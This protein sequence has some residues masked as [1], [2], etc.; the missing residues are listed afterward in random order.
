MNFGS[1]STVKYLELFVDIDLEDAIA[2]SR[3]NQ[4]LSILILVL[5]CLLVCLLLLLLEKILHDK[6]RLRREHGTRDNG[7]VRLNALPVHVAIAA[8][9]CQH[10]YLVARAPNVR[11]LVLAAAH[12]V[13]V[14]RTE[15]RLDVNCG[16][17]EATILAHE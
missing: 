11:A 6:H 16:V 8:A 3:T 9:R 4:H 7:I 12:D 5:V 15:R 13:L 10:R 1:L 14:I 2:A 17:G